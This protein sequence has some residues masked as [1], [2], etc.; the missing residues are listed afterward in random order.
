MYIKINRRKFWC[1][2]LAVMAIGAL[3][4]M[5]LFAGTENPAASDTNTTEIQQLRTQLAEQSKRIDRLYEALAPQLEELEQR[6]AEMKKQAEEDAALKLE[7]VC[8]LKDQD[9]TT[10]AQFSPVDN[11]FAVVTRKGAVLIFSAAGKPLRDLA[12][13][14]ERL[15]AVGYAPDGKRMLVGERALIPLK[16]IAPGQWVTDDKI[17]AEINVPRIA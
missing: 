3:V 13:P 16:E 10:R 4:A 2:R 9:L 14:D 1:W 12:L 5:P 7:T 17:Q 8:V 11:T 6:A 15:A